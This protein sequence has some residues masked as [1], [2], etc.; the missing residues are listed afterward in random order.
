MKEALDG[1]LGKNLSRELE[2]ILKEFIR[3]NYKEDDIY[4]S[5]K[6]FDDISIMGLFLIAT[7]YK[8]NMS[9]YIKKSYNKILNNRV[10]SFKKSV[11]NNNS[12]EF[13]KK[14]EKSSVINLAYHMNLYNLNMEEKEA[15]GP[16]KLKYYKI[17]NEYI[18]KLK[19]Q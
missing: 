4:R 7:K 3:L 15:L 12:E 5:I 16:T 6:G 17:L 10:S 14:L 13:L 1:I 19:V 11:R 2:R 8:N 9:Y 18:D